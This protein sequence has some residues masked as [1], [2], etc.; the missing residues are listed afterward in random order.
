M[1]GASNG[2]GPPRAGSPGTGG[3]DGVGDTEI[4]VFVPE[5]PGVMVRCVRYLGR[6][7]SFC[8]RENS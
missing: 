6:E 3:T 1:G 7:N 5:M 4:P 8:I 2:H